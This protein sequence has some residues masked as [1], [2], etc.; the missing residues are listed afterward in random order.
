MTQKYDTKWPTIAFY[1]N[2]FTQIRALGANTI[3]NW[4]QT[5]R[6][7]LQVQG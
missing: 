1:H 4:S 3:G 6:L 2:I 5:D 7:P